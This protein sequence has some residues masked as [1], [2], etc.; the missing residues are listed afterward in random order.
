V[1]DSAIFTAFADKL[2]AFVASL[3]PEIPV[4]YPNVHFTPPADGVWLEMAWFPNET[5][6][7]GIADDGPAQVRGFGQ[8]S[9][10]SRTGS[11]ALDAL[12][13]AGSIIEWFA[14]GTEL[15][16]ARV[17][18]MPWASSVLQSDDRLVVPVTIRYSGFA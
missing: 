3:S 2:A 11:G 10:C 9:V 17:E 1:S 4:A 16:H 5:R 8:V 14:K 12:D 6:N 15:G 13:L 18:T 7:Y